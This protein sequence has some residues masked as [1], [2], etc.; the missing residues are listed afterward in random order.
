MNFLLGNACRQVPRT[1]AVFALILLGCRKPDNRAGIVGEVYG[2]PESTVVASKVMDIGSTGTDGTVVF[3][4]I[5]SAQQREDGSVLV[6]DRATSEIVEVGADGKIV[7]R[8][9]R[10]GEGPGEY[11]AIGTLQIC[12]RDSVF[13]WDR[14]AERMSIL[15]SDLKFLSHVRYSGRPMEIACTRNDSLVLVVQTPLDMGAPS[16]EAPGLKAPVSVVRFDGSVVKELGDFVVGENRPMGTLTS[17]RMRGDRVAIATAESAY[18]DVVHLPGGR[19]E[20]FSLGGSRQAATQDQ[21]D[22]ALDELAATLTAPKERAA[23]R[24]YLAKVPKPDLLPAYGIVFL[25][26]DGMLFVER[27]S[28]GDS[29]SLFQ[30]VDLTTGRTKGYVRINT[31]LRVLDVHHGSI[32]GVE[33]DQ[34]ATDH[35]V[36]YSIEGA[37]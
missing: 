3:G 23:S 18:V 30:R 2:S 19:Q 8:V 12:G 14:I 22:F 11:R 9:G 4:M 21:Y 20:T 34:S 6:A 29:V 17:F 10:K 33:T 28:P 27:S 24:E 15:T 37:K 26:D 36:V 1:A 31:R 25:S 16:S 35:L 7:R 32:T 5:V 13:V